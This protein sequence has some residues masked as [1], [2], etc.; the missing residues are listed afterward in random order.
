MGVG[1]A[2]G[3]GTLAVGVGVGD[4]V[5]ALSNQVVLVP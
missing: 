3:K 5:L 1:V 4:G 2:V